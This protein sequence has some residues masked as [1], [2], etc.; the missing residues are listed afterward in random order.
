MYLYH[1]NMLFQIAIWYVTANRLFTF[2]ESCVK[3]VCKMHCFQQNRVTSTLFVGQQ[4][5]QRY[6]E[7]CIHV[8]DIFHIA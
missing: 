3:R 6:D 1:L 5:F 4:G 7:G 2:R 8:R